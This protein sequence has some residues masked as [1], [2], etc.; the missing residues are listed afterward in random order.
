MLGQPGFSF[1]GL[2]CE[3]TITI[4]IAVVAF[5][6][7]FPEVPELVLLEVDLDLRGCPERGAGEGD[8]SL[9]TADPAKL[10]RCDWKLGW[11]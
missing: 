5:R 3:L 1:G 4:I 8:G 6:P 9:L 11:V 2:E 7:F 10:E